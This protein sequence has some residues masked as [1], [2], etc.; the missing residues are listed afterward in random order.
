MD[1]LQQLMNSSYPLRG[2]LSGQFHGRGTRQAPAVTGL[3]DLAN[4]EAY[5]VTFSRLRGQLNLTPDEARIAN[6]ELRLFP[7]EK[8]PGHGAGIVTGTAE[9]SFA[10]AKSLRELRAGPT[11]STRPGSLR[12]A[13]A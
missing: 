3:F 1:A 4:G 13:L 8:E 9:Y 10:P 12:W 6:A 5:G 7:T 11:S 2:Q